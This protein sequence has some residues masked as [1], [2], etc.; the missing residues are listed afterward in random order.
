MS[1]F[2][3]TV[4][5]RSAGR[6]VRLPA[7]WDAFGE[8]APVDA[9]ATD[10][11]RR[12]SDAIVAGEAKGEWTAAKQQDTTGRPPLPTFVLL[13]AASRPGHADPSTVPWRPEMTWAATLSR[14]SPAHLRMLE[15]VNEFLRDGGASRPLIPVEERSLE[16]FDDEKAIG[17]TVGGATL[18]RDGRLTLQLLRC[19]P[20]KAPF[21][22]ERVGD[23]DRLLVLENQ[24]TF[25]TC[26][27]LL[28]QEPDHPYAAVAFGGGRAAGTTIPY[29]T[30]LPFPV[31]RVDYFGDLDVDGLEVAGACVRAARR[32][33]VKAAL[34]QPMHRLLA[35]Q[36]AV[37]STVPATDRAD[38]AVAMLDPD[39]AAIARGL[40]A[41][42]LR[43]PQERCSRDLLAATPRWWDTGDHRP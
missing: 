32:C 10:A 22:F 43:V 14:L 18:W 26:R 35:S 21:A 27:D 36:T 3:E 8:A 23:G 9:S 39:V 29:V 28:R 33:G 30:E 6:R 1:D 16:L 42:G 4:R 34:H 40:F 20:S 7:L 5:A 11:R 25:A 12:L 41:A 13:P 37:P 31:A 17:K 38:R 24:A 2:A 19:V 15:R